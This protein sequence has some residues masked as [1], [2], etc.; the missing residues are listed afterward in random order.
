V[1]GLLLRFEEFLIALAYQ[2]KDEVNLRLARETL[3]RLSL[4]QSLQAVP[5]VWSSFLGDFAPGRRSRDAILLGLLTRG[6]FRRN[7]PTL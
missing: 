7:S 3:E 1:D 2:V 6:L 4:H 5:Q